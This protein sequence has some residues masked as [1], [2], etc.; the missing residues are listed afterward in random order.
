MNETYAYKKYVQIRDAKGMTD[1]AV[2][3]ATGGSVAT[4]SLSEWKSNS[5]QLK[6]DKLAKIADALGVQITE[7]IE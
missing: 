4:S 2:S 3:Q 1:Y 5:Y 6:L 7:F